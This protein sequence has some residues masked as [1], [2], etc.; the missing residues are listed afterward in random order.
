M[1]PK[2]GPGCVERQ[3]QPPIAA[4]DTNLAAGRRRHDV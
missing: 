3:A 4:I 2:G 1:L